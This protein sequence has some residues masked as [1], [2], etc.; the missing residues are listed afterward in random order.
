MRT[1]RRAAGDD[2]DAPGRAGQ[3]K[4]PRDRVAPL[5][6]LDPVPDLPGQLVSPGLPQRCRR[7]TES[8]VSG[9]GEDHGELVWRADIG[10][11]RSEHGARARGEDAGANVGPANNYIIVTKQGVAAGIY[12]FRHILTNLTLHI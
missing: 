10:T 2:G 7:A 8:S 3:H 9:D 5:Q 1:L 12:L 11:E 4:P 6:P